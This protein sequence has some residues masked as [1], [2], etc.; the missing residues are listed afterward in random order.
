MGIIDNK[1]RY[2]IQC[3]GRVPEINFIRYAQSQNMK[4]YISN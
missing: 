1:R 3:A 2:R 4:M